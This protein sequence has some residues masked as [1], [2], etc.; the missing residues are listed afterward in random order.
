M[1]KAKS[2]I[3]YLLLTAVMLL[4]G[5]SAKIDDYQ[6]TQPHF[7]IFSYFQ[8]DSRAWGMV[9]DHSG[10]QTRRFAVVIHGEV[11]ADTLTLHE[12]F[13]YNDGEKQT[14]IWHIRRLADGSYKGTAGDIIGVA[15]GREQGNAFNWHYVMDVTSG[16][17]SYRLT[18]DDWLF[19]QDDEHVFNVTSLKKFGVEVAKVTLFFDKK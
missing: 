18:F 13:T 10:K 19:M 5:C 15:V 9:Q 4:A 14:R 6:G 8:G 11:V 1:L 17:S 16:G 12:D 2:Y 3:R 7:D